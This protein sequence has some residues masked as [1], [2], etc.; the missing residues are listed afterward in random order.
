[1]A[2][3]SCSALSACL[4]S[5][6]RSRMRPAMT[7]YFLEGVQ[8][9][10]SA[11]GIMVGILA[12]P[13]RQHVLLRMLDDRQIRREGS[14][15]KQ[16]TRDEEQLS[17]HIPPG[18]EWPATLGGSSC[19]EWSWPASAYAADCAVDTAACPGAARWPGCSAGTATWGP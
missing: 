8:S 1:P 7:A 19:E 13:R 2:C 10:G 18:G 4:R 11:T 6:R 5:S 3:S 16:G 15:E 12:G 14:G 17:Q 9:E